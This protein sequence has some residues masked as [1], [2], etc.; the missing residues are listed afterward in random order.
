MV[1]ARV[2]LFASPKRNSPNTL[3][4]CL[5]LTVS[6]KR[7]PQN[8]VHLC[9][10]FVWSKAYSLL[11]VFLSYSRGLRYLNLHLCLAGGIDYSLMS[12]YES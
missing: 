8:N 12:D 2:E 1:V 10:S 7:N 9:W 3:H 11:F 6:P 5:S 4:L